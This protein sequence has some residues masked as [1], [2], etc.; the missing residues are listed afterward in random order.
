MNLKVLLTFLV[1]LLPVAAQNGIA[2]GVGFLAILG[3]GG[4][5]VHKLLYRNTGFERPLDLAE[6]LTDPSDYFP[7]YATS[8]PLPS[9]IY[10]SFEALDSTITA[11]SD[12]DLVEV[13]SPWTDVE[14]PVAPTSLL[15]E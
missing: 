11:I 13:G 5:G 1:L 4:F 2:Y 3:F 12:D 7:P 6:T 9:P 14:I 8:E 10:T 15:R